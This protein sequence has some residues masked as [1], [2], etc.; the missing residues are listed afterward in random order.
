M[1]A[2]TSEIERLYRA[3]RAGFRNGAAALLGDRDLARD[4]VQ[5]GFVQAIARRGTF[6]GGSL[7]AWVWQIIKRKALD[8]RRAPLA[9]PLEDHFDPDL[10]ISSAAD[11]DLA[12]AIRALPPRRRL[13]VFLRYFADLPY[14]AIAELAGITPG[15]VGA[16]LTQAHEELR[17]ALQPEGV[18]R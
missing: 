12:A 16:A 2:H 18:D 7:E 6:R 8:R 10:L 14:D 5:D 3:K 9:G 15:T 17:G 4:V 11:P 13:I 1:G